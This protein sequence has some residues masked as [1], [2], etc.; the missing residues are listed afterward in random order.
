MGLID[1]VHLPLSRVVNKSL[2]HHIFLSEIIPPRK[3]F[4]NAEN[5]TRGCWVTSANATSVQCQGLARKVGHVL[6]MC[7][8]KLLFRLTY[9]ESKVGHNVLSYSL[10]IQC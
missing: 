10:P 7:N 3:T 5:Q 8:G 1:S 2:Q 6:R 9:L 4:G